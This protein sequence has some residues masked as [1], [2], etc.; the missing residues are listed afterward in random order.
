[1]NK[2]YVNTFLHHLHEKFFW[3]KLCMF[4]IGMFLMALT[5]NLFYVKY[6][7]I[8]IGSNGLAMIISEYVKMDESIIIFCICLFCLLLG[9]ICFDKE[10]GFKMVAF[11]FLFPFFVSFTSL[12]TKKI[13]FEDTSLFLIM[14]FGGGLLGFSSGLIRKSQ[15]SPGGFN[16][17][18]DLCNKYLHISIGEAN[19]AINVFL[20]VAS[21]FT[22]GFESTLY[23][24]ISLLV[25]SYIT[26]KVII[27]ISNNKVFYI[28][29]KKPLEVRDYVQ[30]KLH[31]SVITIKARGGYTNKKRK[32]LMCVVP[33]IEYINLKNIIKEIDKDAFFLIVDTYESSVKNNCKNM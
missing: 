8:S 10:Y 1:M 11:T 26:D 25:S 24:T 4:V 3:K 5:L 17:L 9:F 21:G 7:I 27:G 14:L 30:D 2:I 29:T 33:T 13:N 18:F 15:Y 19:I 28:I 16:V 12:L 6:N 22:Y 23:A 31:Y 20:I 32:M